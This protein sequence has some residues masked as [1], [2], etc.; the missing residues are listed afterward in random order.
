[1]AKLQ[2]TIYRFK[3]EETPYTKEN[4]IKDYAWTTDCRIEFATNAKNP[5]KKTIIDKARRKLEK[6][7]EKK[8]GDY[9]YSLYL[10]NVWYKLL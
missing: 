3:K 4:G 5:D 10:Q 7:K 9:R 1:M 2:G 8:E 6:S